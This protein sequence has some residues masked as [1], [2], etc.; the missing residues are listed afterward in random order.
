M[1]SKR[2]HL[3]FI[4][5]LFLVSLF[6]GYQHIIIKKPQSIHKWRQADCASIALNYYQNGMHFFEPQVNNLTSD[7]GTSGKCMTS[8]VPILYYS[9]AILYKVFGYHDFLFRLLNTLLFF[10]GLFYL[11]KTILLL[12]KDTFWSIALTLLIFS[13]PVLVYYGNNY[14]SNSTAFAFTL[15]GWYF[16]IR[17]LLEKQRRLFYIS[18]LIFF[19]AAM[20]KVTA[21]FSLFAIAGVY[22][23]ETLK[24]NC[25]PEISGLF[26]KR[27]YF[28]LPVILVVLIIGAWLMYVSHYNS[29]HGCTYFSTTIFP[30][31]NYDQETILTIITQIYLNWGPQ[32]FHPT[33]FV[34]LFIAIGFI[35]SRSNKTSQL[36]TWVIIF[37]LVEEIAYFL[38]QFWTFR[39]HDYYTIDMF[40]LA[41][42]II[43]ASIQYLNAR[44]PAVLRSV[45]IKAV[46]A[47]F[48]GFNLYYA[49]TKLVDR[50]SDKINDFKQTEDLYTITPYLRSIGISSNDTVIS[51][52][53]YSHVSLYLMNQKGWTEYTEHQFNREVSY[54]YNADSLSVSESIRKGARYLILNGIGE[55]YAKPY[56]QSFCT[57]L[58][59]H[60]NNVLIFQLNNAEQNFSLKM[61]VLMNS[62]VC[63]AEML[64]VDGQHY[65]NIEGQ[66]FAGGDT[67]TDQFSLSGHFSCQLDAN[68]PYGMAIKL[69]GL[70]KGESIRINTWRKINGSKAS[71]LIVSGENYYNS[72]YK[73]K[74]KDSLGW[75]KLENELFISS[76]LEG[77][78]IGIYLFNSGKDT[79]YFD[80]LSVKWFGSTPIDRLLTNDYTKNGINLYTSHK[81]GVNPKVPTTTT[82]TTI[83]LFQQMLTKAGFYNSYD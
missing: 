66:L 8:E 4:L 77:K 45:W 39:D 64:T 27:R 51:I 74:H 81:Y 24:I 60:Y 20:F 23:V 82:T 73:I 70:K 6:Y 9:S 57:Y 62:Y 78:E 53:D 37:L 71:S 43:F 18:L 11:F 83:V 38:L 19:C 17:F 42:V 21:F 72:D 34:V 41:V 26:T 44:H 48:I 50:Y 1:N 79:V 76:E 29:I 47:L 68:H 31:W 2:P 46:F 59:G 32:Y 61:R 52:P 65:T 40:I 10:L 14:L 30:I 80:N 7:G 55:L 13:S 36:L 67:R 58:L 16:F 63:D 54:S 22:L 56:L 5:I 12:S 25:L 15:V 33:V 28:M 69:N 75:E 3:L 35:L 49:R